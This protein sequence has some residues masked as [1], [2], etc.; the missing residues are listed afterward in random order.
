MPDLVEKHE[1]KTEIIQ[2]PAEADFRLLQRKAMVMQASG[3]FADCQSAAQAVAKALLGAE[4]GLDVA[5]SMQN[6]QVIKGN[7]S[8][9]YIAL[10]ALVKRSGRY[11]WQIKPIHQKDEAG[12]IIIRNGEPV[13]DGFHSDERHCIIEFFRVEKRRDGTRNLIKFAEESFTI[14]DAAREGL[15]SRPNY[16]TMPKIMLRARC[17]SRGVNTHCSDVLGGA[18]YVPEDFGFSSEAAIKQADVA[19]APVEAKET[20]KVQRKKKIAPKKRAKKPEPKPLPE[21]R[22]EMDAEF[23]RQMARD[24]PSEA[25]VVDADFTE[26]SAKQ[27]DALPF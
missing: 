17:I 8:L 21:Q 1:E 10:G 11:W 7:P 4:F 15:A 24:E 12:N 18:A 13:V 16:K 20:I 9:K 27:L 3:W 2:T 5:M 19:D 26:E 14:E 22:N 25:L 6:V 23:E